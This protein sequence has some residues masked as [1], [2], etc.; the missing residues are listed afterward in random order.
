MDRIS[1]LTQTQQ[2]FLRAFFEVQTSEEPFYLSGGTALAGYYLEH[3]YSDDLD[4]FTRNPEALRFVEERVQRAAAE[5]G[6][7]VERADLKGELVRYFFS[8]DP[9]PEHP[10]GKVELILD[11]LPHFAPPRRFGSILVDDLLCIA[12]NK[13]T[14]HTRFD[15]KDYVDLYLI[16]RSGAYRLEDLIPLAKQKMIGLDEL[17]IA[18]RFKQ[19]GQLQNLA[20]FQQRYMLTRIDWRELVRFYQEWAGRLFALFPPRRQE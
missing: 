10:L 13:L 20:Q 6:L 8:G 5:A 17:A 9:H 15:P 4:F 2:R 19:V 12:V 14:I 1:V 11:T 3:R 7:Q 18:E 16:V